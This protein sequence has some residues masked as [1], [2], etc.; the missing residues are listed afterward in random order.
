MNQSEL[1][2][3]QRKRGGIKDGDAPD[4]P[5]VVRPVPAPP[6]T[7]ARVVVCHAANHI[8]RRIHSVQESPE[9]EESPGDQQLRP[10]G[11]NE[12][13]SRAISLWRAPRR[14]SKKTLMRGCSWTDL[15]PNDDEVPEPDDGELARSE[16]LPGLCV[17]ERDDVDVV[18]EDL[19]RQNREDKAQQVLEDRSRGRW[20]GVDDLSSRDQQGRSERVACGL[21]GR[22]DGV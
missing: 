9:A 19:H 7:R 5:E 2:L 14:R 3:R 21:M 1:S 16:T 17:L 8:L 11:T 18:Q 6:E 20:G 12:R 13:V 22:V 4:D 10:S 15:E